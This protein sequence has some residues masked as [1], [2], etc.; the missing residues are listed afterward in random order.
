MESVSIFGAGAQGRLAA[1]IL[2]KEGFVIDYFIDNDPAKQGKEFLGIRVMSLENFCSSGKESRIVIACSPDYQK[3]I[4]VQLKK[5]GLTKYEVFRKERILFKERLM[6]YSYPTENEDIILYHV[7]KSMPSEDIYWID[8]GSNDP[9]IGSVT[10]LFY[11]RG[12]CG[13]NI[14]M[15]KNLIDITKGVRKRDVNLWTA[16]GS[17][18]GSIDFYSQGDYGGLSTAV[19]EF[20]ENEGALKQTVP[21]TTLNK[22]CDEYVVKSLTFLKIDVEGMEKEVL[23][24]MDFS[25]YRPWILIIESTLPK[26][27]IPDYEKWES[28]VREAGYHFVYTHGVNRYYVADEKSDLDPLFVPWEDMVSEYCIL[29][30]D[31]LYAV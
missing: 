15:E 6:S 16:V 21:I 18:D 7:L 28:I 29:H 30:P 1:V 10:Q 31:L 25:K 12:G 4:L 2:K 19:T 8:V 26:T 27:M 9:Y 3:Q 17:K 11:E 24:G 13:I 5:R 14:D 23:L 20:V 22:I